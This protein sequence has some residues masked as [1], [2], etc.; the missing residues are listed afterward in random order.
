MNG[1]EEDLIVYGRDPSPEEMEDVRWAGDT[2]RREIAL[3][4]ESLRQV[5]T[6]AAGLL[7][8]PPSGAG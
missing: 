1:P 6:L 3:L 2:R 8:A 7:A 5:I 4:N